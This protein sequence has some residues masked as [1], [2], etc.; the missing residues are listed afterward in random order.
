MPSPCRVFRVLAID[1][2]EDDQL[3]FQRWLRRNATAPFVK[4]MDSAADAIRYLESL[5][6]NAP[7]LPHV[8]FCDVKMPGVDGFDFLRWLRSSP[9]K[10][11]PVVMRSSSPITADVERAYTLGA[12]SYVVKRM[13][14]DAMEQRINDLVHYWRDIAEVPGR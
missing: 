5:P 9:H 4:M 6:S 7:E 3:I 10:H 8:I 14:L 1:D 2:D 13:D 12:N 11:I